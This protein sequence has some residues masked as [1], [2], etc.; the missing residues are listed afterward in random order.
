MCEILTKVN[1]PHCHSSKVVKNGKKR[2]GTQCFLCKQCRKQFQNEYLYWGANPANKQLIIRLLLRGSSIRDCAAVLQISLPCVLNCLLKAAESLV[3]YPLKKHYSLVQVDEFWTF[4]GE[5]KK[6]KYWFIYAY[7]PDND[8]IL[9]YVW[10]KRDEKTVKELYALL[11]DVEIDWICSD[12]WK[13]FAKVFPYEKHLIGKRFTK[14]IEGVNTYLRVRNRR[15][16]RRTTCFSK[17]KQNHFLTMN[18]T[19]AYRN[20]NHHA[21]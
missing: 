6:R 3:V 21:F 2:T 8:E 13:A 5:K 17:K 11:S 15:V 12:S 7:S 16:F 20:Y 1:C 19:V 4:V 14:A 9:T 10:G 18:L